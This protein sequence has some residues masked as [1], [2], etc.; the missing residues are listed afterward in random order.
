MVLHPTP[1]I[2]AA[3]PNQFGH[4]AAGREVIVT[5]A[6]KKLRNIFFYHTT[7]QPVILPWDN[8]I[9]LRVAPTSALPPTKCMPCQSICACA[10]N[11]SLSLYHFCPKRNDIIW[12]LELGKIWRQMLPYLHLRRY[13]VAET[14]YLLSNACNWGT[15]TKQ[16]NHPCLCRTKMW[17]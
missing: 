12:Q 13:A 9:V 1:G 10:I 8:Y 16:S 2:R 4:V 17:M 7:T 14:N 15:K 6:C 11:L 3:N 5:Y